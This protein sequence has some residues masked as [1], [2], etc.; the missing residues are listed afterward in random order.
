MYMDAVVFAGI[1]TVLLMVVFFVG[2][3][4]FVMRDQKAHGGK[5]R[6]KDVKTGGTAI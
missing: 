6:K 4:V 3:G 1:A 5:T 2:V